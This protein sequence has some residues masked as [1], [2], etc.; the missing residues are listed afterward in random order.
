[1]AAPAFAVFQYDHAGRLKLG[2]VRVAIIFALVALAGLVALLV[3]VPL[4]IVALFIAI[5]VSATLW[6]K[7]RILLGSRYM[8]CGNT[9]LFYRNV[10]ALKLVPGKVLTIQSEGKVLK[11]ERERFPT[12]ARK[13]HKIEANTRAKFDKVAVKIIQRV[14]Q[15]RPS[16]EL[17]GIDRGAYLSADT[18]KGKA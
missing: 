12:G 10:R 9:I 3:A 4:G 13:A 18:T 11:V 1:M 17:R 14:V 8:L 7:R 16:V 5:A 2:P 15:A 6:P